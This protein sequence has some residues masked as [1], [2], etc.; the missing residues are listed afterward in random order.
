MA[1]GNAC[2]VPFN[3]CIPFYPGPKLP[4]ALVQP[5]SLKIVPKPVQ[6]VH[7][8]HLVACAGGLRHVAASLS[9]GLSQKTNLHRAE[10]AAIYTLFL[11][12]P[13]AYFTIIDTNKFKY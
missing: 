5:V 1:K 4:Q 3:G 7:N 6:F 13:L 8:I 2:L 12:T 10:E 11:S 9:C